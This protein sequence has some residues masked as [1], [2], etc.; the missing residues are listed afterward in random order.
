MRHGIINLVAKMRGTFPRWPKGVPLIQVYMSPITGA[1]TVLDGNHRAW[2]ASEVGYAAIPAIQVR[3]EVVRH[4]LAKHEG[5][6]VDAEDE[7]IAVLQGAGWEGA[8]DVRGGLR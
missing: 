1:L 6:W 4:L 3:D 8:E 5:N 2:A 7:M